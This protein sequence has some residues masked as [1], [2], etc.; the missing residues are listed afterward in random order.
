[1]PQDNPG[2]PVWA[3]LKA[4]DWSGS[5]LIVGGTLMLLLGLNFGGVTF[6]WSSAT[7]I[8]LIVFGIFAGF[9]FGINEWK[10]VKYP[11]VPPRLF[12]K[13][14]SIA[15]FVVCFF[16][17]VVLFGIAYYLPLYFQSVLGVGP[18]LSGV[19]LLPFIIT[20]PIMAAGTGVYIQKTGKYIPPM[21]VGLVLMVLGIGLFIDLDSNVNWTKIVCYQML[22]AAGIGMNFEGPLLALQASV[23]IQ[24]VATA[25]ATF[26]F[27]RMLSAA[28]S[29][30]IG[31]VV[32]QNQM[33]KESTTL[34]Q[35]GPEVASQLQGAKATVN[36]GVIKTLPLSQQIIARGA[37]YRS[38][39][40]M[41]IMVNIPAEAFIL[42]MV[43]SIH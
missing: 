5:L 26:G 9:L 32:F 15:S 4:I 38:L 18:L 8:N 42:T 20:N 7:V 35:L 25:T 31:G 23:D 17:G 27:T 24:D 21:Y 29:A 12:R 40:T 22:A 19:Y 34:A 37:Y 2:T 36:L 14:T 11:V 10:L 1:M 3:G 28:I 6:S 30:V 33:I 43:T 39:R 13:R 16:H 41:W